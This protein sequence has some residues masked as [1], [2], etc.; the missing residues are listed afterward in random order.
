MGNAGQMTAINIP[1]D[2]RLLILDGMGAPVVGASFDAVST[3][4]SWSPTVNFRADATDGATRSAM[5]PLLGYD[6]VILSSWGFASD[7]LV[8]RR[9]YLS[10]AIGAGLPADYLRVWRHDAVAGWTQYDATDL[11]YTDEWA[12]FTIIELGTYAVTG[13]PEP[14]TLFVMGCGAIGLLRRPRSKIRRGGRA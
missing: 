6:E 2:Q 8:G 5:L 11:T 12:M 1:D 9:L 13:V 14:A 3:S 7:L 10:F 4:Q